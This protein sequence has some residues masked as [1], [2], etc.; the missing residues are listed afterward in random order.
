[1]TTK[2]LACDFR[3]EEGKAQQQN[4]A[5]FRSIFHGLRAE[6]I[7]LLELGSEEV[8]ERKIGIY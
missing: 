1:M 8:K 7:C 2:L 4:D 5:Y 3:A 6:K